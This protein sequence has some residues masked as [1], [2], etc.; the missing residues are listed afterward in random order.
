MAH[1]L[2]PSCHL[3]HAGTCA[4]LVNGGERSL[5][6]NLAAA[7]TFQPSHLDTPVA[8]DMIGSAKIVYIAGFFL[9]VSPPSLQRVAAAVAANGGKFAFNLSAPFLVDFFSEPMAAA[10][11]AA[12]YVFG[13][14][15]EAAA[16]GSKHGHGSDIAEVAKTIAALPQS[17]GGDGKSRPPRTVVITQG[18]DPTIV[19]TGN[20]DVQTFDVVPLQDGELVDTNGAG[21]AFVGGFLAQ[22]MAG[23]PLEKAVDAGHWAARQIIQ[24]S[25][26]TFPSTC[27][28]K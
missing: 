4:V 11:E 12:D 13:N 28:Y 6:A 8:A 25:G 2:S 16:Y 14:E 22:L 10:L 1:S 26:C 3:S 21:D 17:G 19:V 18:K 7:N 27:D 23:Q 20:G 24:R 9:T 15:S 5:V